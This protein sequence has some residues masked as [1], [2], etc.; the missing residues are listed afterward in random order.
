MGWIESF[1]HIEFICLFIFT[2]YSFAKLFRNKITFYAIKLWKRHNVKYNL[3]SDNGLNAI[4]ETS[5][6]YQV[7]NSECFVYFIILI[8]VFGFFVLFSRLMLNSVVDILL[9]LLFLTISI[10]IS[11][12]GISK[13]TFRYRSTIIIITL[14]SLILLVL[15]GLELINYTSTEFNYINTI[16]YLWMVISHYRFANHILGKL[17]TK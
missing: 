2:L 11:L 8:I 10:V 6:K 13:S 4:N 16:L 7:I 5:L 9:Y 15:F 17:K 14:L 3:P 1:F 12:Q